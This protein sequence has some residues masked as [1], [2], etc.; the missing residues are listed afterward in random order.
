VKSLKTTTRWGLVMLCFAGCVWAGRA[1]GAEAPAAG[2]SKWPLQLDGDRGRIVIYQPQIESYQGNIL[3]ARAAVA[4]TPKGKKEPVFGAIWFKSRMS[5]DLDTRLISC[6]DLEVTAAKFPTLNDVQVERLSSYLETEIPKW[7][8]DLDLDRFLATV[9]QAE[10]HAGGAPAFDNNPPE[11]IFAQVPA[12][13]VVIE[14]EPQLAKMDGYDLEYV[15]NTPFFIA[16]DPRSGWYYLRGGGYWYASTDLMTG[17][18]KIDE[19]PGD[20]ARVAKAVEEEERNQEAQATGQGTPSEQPMSAGRPAAIPEIIVRT[21]PAELI[22]TDGEPKFVPL[23]GTQLLYVENT[24][25][26]ILMDLPTQTYYLLISGRWYESSSLEGGDWKFVNPEKLPA[27][28]AMIEPDSEVGSVLAS[29]PGTQEAREAVLENTIPQTAEVDRQTTTVTVSYDGDPEFET[30]SSDVAYA[31]NTDKVVF[32]IDGRYY[33]CDQAVWFW[34]NG[35]SGPWQV[36]TAVPNQIQ[37]IPPECPY[38]N[39]KYVYIYDSTPEAVYVGYTPG[40][41][42]S[43]VYYGTVVYGTGY[44][45]RPWYHHHYYPRPV[46]WGFHAHWNP[47]TGWGFSTGVSFG[48][49]H[50]S[51]GRPWYGGWWGPAGYRHGYYHGYRHGYY[52]G[53]RAGYRAGYRAAQPTPYKNVYASHQR[54]GV[55]AGGKPA[56]QPVRHPKPAQQ[57]NNVYAGKDGRVYRNKG[58]QWQTNQ[59]GGWTGSSQ[60][61]KQNMARQQQSRQR[62]EQK[63]R[64]HNPQRTKSGGGRKR[65]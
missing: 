2:G 63:S 58:G 56:T 29:V 65:R 44:W 39:V 35:P 31:V 18:K 10:S 21:H 15:A 34:A 30:C 40:Y 23:Q 50:I 62:G 59:K 49:L 27:D 46:T 61:S 43:Y 32:L 1:L 6:E 11:I 47:V 45:Y 57:P 4:V 37:D 51:V 33:C 16:R 60:K 24:Q 64:Q 22:Q 38:Y 7:E 28:F 9:E 41:T 14:G 25:D 8:I 20:V 13:L 48:W 52:H 42:C 26:D 5:T 3:E 55:S 54:R 12:V 53:A 36:A 17:W 19:L